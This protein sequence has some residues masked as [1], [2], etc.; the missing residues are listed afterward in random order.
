MKSSKEIAQRAMQ[1]AGWKAAQYQGNITQNY[2]ME[3]TSHENQFQRH[4][5]HCR[6]CY[7]QGSRTRRVLCRDAIRLL[8]EMRLERQQDGQPG[9]AQRTEAQPDARLIDA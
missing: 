8:Q 2:P 3:D 1:N 5:T 4:L 7:F 6:Y 9:R